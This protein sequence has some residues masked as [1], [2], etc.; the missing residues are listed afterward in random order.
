MHA[1]TY[2]HET[3]PGN[4]EARETYC[5]H[6]PTYP[7]RV[8]V[9]VGGQGSSLPVSPLSQQKLQIPIRGTENDATDSELHVYDGHGGV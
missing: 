7:D 1:P 3:P 8:E 6:G 4:T 5:P 9:V 2:S